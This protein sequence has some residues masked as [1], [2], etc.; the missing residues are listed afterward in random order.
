MSSQIDLASI[1]QQYF[2]T[3]PGQAVPGAESHYEQAVYEAPRDTIGQGLAEAFRAEQ[4]PAAEQMVAQLFGRSN[5]L[6]HAGLLN[7]LMRTLGPVVLASIAG[8]VMSGLQQ[9]KAPSVGGGATQSSYVP[10]PQVTPQ[11]AQQ[12]TPQQISE[13]TKRAT[14]QDPTV[15]DRLG[16]FY[17]QHPDLVKTLGGAALT[18]ALAKIA[19]GM[20]RG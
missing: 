5:P 3:P 10:P 12:V 2:T 9:A 13:I 7:Q 4:T 19:Q 14:E 15:L 18:V 17:A 6:Q 1:L 20:R 8:K 11:Q 16:G